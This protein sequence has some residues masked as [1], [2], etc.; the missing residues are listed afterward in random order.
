[1]VNS[2]NITIVRRAPDAKQAS[3]GLLRL[4]PLSVLPSLGLYVHLPWCVKKCP[5]CDFNSH[6]V[7]QTQLTSALEEQY[8]QAL[9]RDLEAALPAIW[10]RSV[11]TVFIGGG[12]PSL[13]QARSIE[14]LLNSVRARLRLAAR[15]EITLEANPGTFESEKFAGFAA[16]GVTRL[17]IGVQ[18][19][20]AKH[21]LALG[22]IHSS[23]QAEQAIEL[24]RR[25]FSTWNIDLMYGLPEQTPE[26]ALL[27][28][29]KALAFDPP[30]LSLYNLTLEPNTVFAI[31]PPQLPDDDTIAS[32]QDALHALLESSGYVRYEVSAWAK[33]GHE[34]AHNRNY[35]EFGDYL[36]IGAGAHSKISYPQPLLTS[37]TGS[38]IE[39]QT[40]WRTPQE[41]LKQSHSGAISQQF[42][43]EVDQ[44]PFEFM[45]NAL[46]LID[47]V[48]MQMFFE[49]TG[50]SV[51]DIHDALEKARH[52]QLIDPNPSVLKATELG[53]LF[54][55]DLQELFLN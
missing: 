46:R 44:L 52:K 39:R 28:L 19:F 24:A 49:R 26:Q 17:S 21:L 55:N 16:A 10:G 18:S 4:R 40:R 25:E 42:S 7:G 43:V 23:T 6:E 30:H 13:F 53:L 31:R 3:E 48:P 12:T 34:C 9:E 47:G 14:T 37:V 38:S 15:A 32:M 22:R 54:L 2:K 45:L 8:I 51:I 11:Q 29:T 5:Y 20:N 27:D 36:G 35:W 50:C 1:L 33:P 41:Y